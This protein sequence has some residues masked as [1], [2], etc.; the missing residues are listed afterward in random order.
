MRST[1][2]GVA[3]NWLKFPTAETAV[4]ALLDVS[5]AAGVGLALAL[6]G[7][8]HLRRSGR[9]LLVTWLGVWA[10]APFA[11]ALGVSVGRPIYLD[12]YLIIAAPAFALLAGVALTALPLRFRVVGAVAAVVGTGVGLGLWYAAA[13]EDGNWRAEDWRSAVTAVLEREDE[14]DAIVVAPW[15]AR[16]AAR[17][18]GA[19]VV[20]TSTAASIWVLTWSETGD[21]LAS[22][23]RRALGFGEHRLVERIPFGW[24]VH[25]ELWRR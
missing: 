13:T 18:Y 1:G 20:D 7:L 21:E 17:Y 9:A 3:M 4:R 15:S 2:E 11:L 5:G 19:E 12:R 24:R 6:G 8:W 22:A 16:P 10:F 23:E 25:A 14:A